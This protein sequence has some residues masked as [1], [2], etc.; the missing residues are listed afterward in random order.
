MGQTGVI[1]GKDILAWGA[2]A[3]MGYTFAGI[4]WQP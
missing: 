3:R 1:G 4:P 2:G